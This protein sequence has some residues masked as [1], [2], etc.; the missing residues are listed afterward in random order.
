MG[1]RELVHT[2]S[3]LVEIEG[4]FTHEYVTEVYEHSGQVSMVL[5]EAK[6][7]PH[8]KCGS[9]QC[10]GSGIRCFFTLRI[11][12]AFI[13]DPGSATLVPQH[14]FKQ[15]P[16]INSYI[17]QI[18]AFVLEKPKDPTFYEQHNLP[19]DARQKFLNNHPFI[20]LKV[21][22][23]H[24]SVVDPKLFF[25]DPIFRRVLDPDLDPT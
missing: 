23:V 7:R 22:T 3:L 24:C 25:P 4:H 9:A 11:R 21:R 20:S 17:F 6:G 19:P 16:T 15:L 1:R 10:C 14:Q 8:K 18:V 13:P 2:F 5:I 12:D